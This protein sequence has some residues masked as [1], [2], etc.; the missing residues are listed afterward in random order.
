MKI[1]GIIAEYNPFHNGHQYHLQKSIEQS[2]ADYSVIVMSGNFVQRGTPALADKYIR[3]ETA[4]RC[5]ADLV[6]ELPSFY[7]TGSAEFFA[8]GAVSLLD[9]LG[10][11]THLCFGSECG[12]LSL[13]QK[14]ASILA[15]EPE[16]Y[17]TILRNKLREGSSFPTARSTA[18]LECCPELG[19]NLQVLT[20]PNNILGIEYLKAL[21]KQNSSI[22]PLTITRSGSNYHDQE[23]TTTL[24]SATAIRQALRDGLSLSHISEY[25]PHP[26]Y[27]VLE[28]HFLN[29]PPIFSED[30]SSMLYYKLL[31]EQDEGYTAYMD[32]SEEISDRIRRNLYQFTTFPAFCALLKTK[33]ITHSR[34]SRCLIHI[35]LN[36]RKA[37]LEHYVRTLDYT[38]YA[39]I[40]GFRQAS[41]PLLSAISK[42]TRI[43]LITKLADAG[44]ILSEDALEMLQKDI[45][46][47]HI[48]NSIVTA[49]T[50]RPMRN[51]YSTPLVIL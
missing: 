32:V 45:A 30:L 10:A 16:I 12:V 17:K 24:S 28:E 40:L 9:K 35:L 7:A 44:N 21:Y 41:S 22:N 15:E 1:C 33:E 26:A 49:K 48:Y 39:R 43:P 11:V 19:E 13:L 47:S 38:P 8:A 4:L 51:E 31:C 34:I 5:G 6:L 20:A 18:L 25:L 27:S 23:L 3:T 29:I 50:E 37:D 42:Q 46:I 14:A 36:I 2:K